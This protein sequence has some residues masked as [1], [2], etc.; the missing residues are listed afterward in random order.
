MKQKASRD[1]EAKF[2]KP[3][4]KSCILKSLC[5]SDLAWSCVLLCKLVIVFLSCVR[6]RSKSGELTETRFGG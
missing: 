5:G 2:L 3:F 4:Q 1:L 6:L